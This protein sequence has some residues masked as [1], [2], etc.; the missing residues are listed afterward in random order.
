M[1]GQRSRCKWLK[2]G[3]KNTRFFHGMA[4]L[5][6]IINRISSLT[7]G[8]RRLDW[9]EEIIKHIEEYFTNLYSEDR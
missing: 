7:D 6:K 8:D 3:Y 9:K 1:W 5:R 2:E 4:S